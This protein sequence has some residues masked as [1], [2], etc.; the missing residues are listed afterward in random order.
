MINTLLNFVKP[1]HSRKK[2]FSDI[3]KPPIS[4]GELTYLTMSEGITV[5]FLET[6]T[7]SPQPLFNA[8]T[9]EINDEIIQDTSLSKGQDALQIGK[10]WE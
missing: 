10:T 5:S 8:G 9:G 1:I 4:A 3:R 6:K 2:E 7:E